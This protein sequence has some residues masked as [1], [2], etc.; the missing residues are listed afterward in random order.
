MKLNRPYS[1][2]SH[3]FKFSEWNK[4]FN[5]ELWVQLWKFKILLWIPNHD[6][7]HQ[8]L[9][10]INFY[11]SIFTAKIN[12]NIFQNKEKTQFLGQFSLKGIFSKNFSYVQLQ[13]SP[14]IYMSKIRVDRFSNQKL[15]HHYQHAKTVVN[16]LNSW[17][18]LWD[19]PDLTVP[20]SIKHHQF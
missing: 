5:K 16:L 6:L 10:N 20:W 2:P 7:L 14:N 15:F 11:S 19:I 18:N 12:D 8:T 13:E 3:Y 9:N 1:T 4:E 17:N